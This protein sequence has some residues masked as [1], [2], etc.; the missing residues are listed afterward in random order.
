MW[1]AAAAGGRSIKKSMLAPFLYEPQLPKG[2]REKA[3]QTDGGG[4][5]GVRLCVFYDIREKVLLRAATMNHTTIRIK[6]NRE[7]TLF[8]DVE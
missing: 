5:T 3:A 6:E 1:I 4:A 8:P 7:E 2:E